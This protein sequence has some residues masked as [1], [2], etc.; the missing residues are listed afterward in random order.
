SHECTGRPLLIAT[1]AEG[2]EI[3]RLSPRGGWEPTLSHEELGRAGDLA[4]T[5][6]E[7]R[8]IG[9]ML[10]DAGVNWNLAP[11]VDVGYNPANPVIVEHGRSFAA[12]PLRVAAQARAYLRGLRA[13]DIL[14]TLKHF[15]GHGSSYADSHAGFV[16]VTETA[17][18]AIEL[19]PY[20]ALL[21]EGLVDAVMTA[22]VFNRRQDPDF[23]ATLSPAT[24]TGLLRQELQWAGVIVS[25]DM[26]MG[27]ISADYGADRRR[28]ARRRPVRRRLRARR[29]PP[30]GRGRTALRRADRGVTRADPSTD[31]QALSAGPRQRDTRCRT[32]PRSGPRRRPRRRRGRAAQRP[33]GPERPRSASTSARRGR[34]GRAPRLVQASA[35]AAVANRSACQ[36]A[37]PSASPTARAPLKASPAAVVST[38]VTGN[39]GTARSPAAAEASAPRSPSVTTTAPTPRARRRRP[40]ARASPSSATLTPPR[41]AASLSLGVR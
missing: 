18:A 14:T 7:A 40:T 15:P 4:L 16:D 20:R 22:H 17:D 39:A 36:R 3:M 37:A 26:R 2:G 1:D 25:D 38:A 41:R 9:F 5:E 24:L 10:R 8:R 33:T 32:S 35:A 23:P 34:E 29:A 30:G 21:G 11:V 12:N 28:P 6:L 31:G 27:A 13:A 19:Y